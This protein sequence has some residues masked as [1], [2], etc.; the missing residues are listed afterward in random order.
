MVVVIVCSDFCVVLKG[1]Y[2]LTLPVVTTTQVCTFFS[3]ELSMSYGLFS[4]SSSFHRMFPLF[5]LWPL[6]QIWVI[7]SGNYRELVGVCF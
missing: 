5:L 2:Q 6:L 4:M 3:Q 7:E 1:I